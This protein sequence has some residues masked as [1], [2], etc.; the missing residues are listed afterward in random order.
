MR[1]SFILSLIIC[2]LLGANELD[3]NYSTQLENIEADPL[4]TIELKSGASLFEAIV[5]SLSHNAKI[6][7]SKQRV[8][9]ELASQSEKDAGHLPTL[10]LFGD[11]GYEKRS[12]ETDANVNPT[13][14]VT[15]YNYKKTELFFTFTENIYA[16]GAIENA[17]NEQRARVEATIYDHRNNLERASTEVISAYF[18]VIYNQIALKVNNKNMR[19]FEEILNI[20]S[21]KEEN[22]AATSG[23]VNFIKANVESAKTDRVKTEAKL[24]NAISQYEYLLGFYDETNQPFESH[25]EIN[26]GELNTSL[27]LL[28]KNNALIL[29]QKSYI[30]SAQFSLDG[31]KATFT[32]KVDFQVNGE[33]R[34]EFDRGLGERNKLNALV[35]FNYNLY[36][37]GKD[38]ARYQ[39]FYAKLSEQ[40]FLLQDRRRELK[41]QTKVLYKSVT[42]S[43]E[44]LKLTASEVTSAR[45]VV[46]SYWIAFQNGTQ[47][48][49][50]LQLAQANLNRS[51]LDFVEYKKSMSINYFKLLQLT[52]GLLPYL[53]I[54]YAS[55]PS[56]FKN[57]EVNFWEN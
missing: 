48:L 49:Q 5:Y 41:F 25:V 19:K 20:V 17:V 7:A 2:T 3:N 37:G 43:L 34:N 42:S 10:T 15:E 16:G 13:A 55:R 28:E 51:E 8:L 22:G 57:N 12:S 45:K 24:S 54:N 46:D 9:Q 38:Q 27:D 23:D 40:K 21:I 6:K 29:R 36:N 11:A 52:G 47:N 33:A 1:K 30:T 53:D 39:R 35:N 44:S 14:Q 31:T 18:N 26:T 50:S 56:G 32:P 4:F